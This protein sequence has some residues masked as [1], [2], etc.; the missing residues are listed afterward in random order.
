MLES[1]WWVP[2]E[3]H[4]LRLNLLQ[5]LIALFLFGQEEKKCKMNQSLAITWKHHLRRKL[6]KRGTN[7]SSYVLLR[8]TNFKSFLI[9][10][11]YHHFIVKHCSQRRTMCDD[12]TTTKQEQR[13][14]MSERKRWSLTHEPHFWR[15]SL[16]QWL[17]LCS[18]SEKKFTS[19]RWI[20]H[21]Q[22]STGNIIFVYHWA[23]ETHQHIYCSARQTTRVSPFLTHNLQ[24]IHHQT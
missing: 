16:L 15:L 11:T 20:N 9:P 7:P 5:W 14:S 21:W 22:T 3:P 2:H 6:G 23:R 13:M 4:F 19:A 18:R 10:H 1:K 8:K 24:S 12:T 17:T